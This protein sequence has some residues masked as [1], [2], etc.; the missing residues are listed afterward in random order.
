MKKELVK[1]K[2]VHLE[3]LCEFE[4]ELEANIDEIEE[5]ALEV[6]HSSGLESFMKI[7]KLRDRGY[8]GTKIRCCKCGKPAHYQED[9][10]RSLSL[11]FAEVEILRSR[12]KCSTCGTSFYPLDRELKL[13]PGKHQGRM[14][15]RAE[16][17]AVTNSY[18]QASKLSAIFL[19]TTVSD[20]QLRALTS[21]CSEAFEAS[22]HH[23]IPLKVELEDNLYIQIDGNMCPTREKRRDKKDNGYREAKTVVAFTEVAQVSE[24]RREILNKSAACTICDKSDFDEILGEFFG[25]RVCTDNAKQV[26][27]IADGAH[28]IWDLIEIHCPEAECILDYTHAKQYLYKAAEIIYGKSCEFSRA[29]VKKQEDLLFEDKLSQI[30]ATIESHND[31]HKLD[32][33]ITYFNNNRSRMKYG[34]YTKKGYFIGSGTV[35]S[36]A[37]SIVQ[38]RLKGPGMRWNIKDANKLIPLRA[39]LYD[40]RLL[41]YWNKAQIAA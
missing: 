7:L 36:A 33:I 9:E 35:E 31:N 12:Y 4:E 32:S 39:A 22:D 25:N 15:K 21:R 28:W 24:K 8:K 30:I 16:C 14:K 3:N 20:V 37:K 10:Y 34:T 18:Q 27:A 17:L 1:I 29:W 40:G 41:D 13:S 38:L 26:V 19:E 6:A 11:V 23:N 5:K 2:R